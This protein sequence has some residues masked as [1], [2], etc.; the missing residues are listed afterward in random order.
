MPQ[1]GSSCAAISRRSMARC[2]PTAW[3]FR[4]TG[5]PPTAKPRRLDFWLHGRGEKLDELAFIEDRL[6]NKGE[7]TPAG[8]IVL[9]LYGRYCNA[10]KF[11]GE[12][13]PFR[14][15]RR[16]A[17]ALRDRLTAARRARLLDGRREH[18]AVRHASS[19]AC[20]PRRRRARALPRPRSFSKSSAEG[21]DAA[22]LV[23]AGA[24]ALV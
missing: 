10:N 11:A 20:G 24:L 8:A 22:A 13:G 19:P 12:S 5:S 6:K 17:E 18:L 23:G 9:H 4:T 16:R 21:K 1:P 2:S 15:A 7:F 3:S 14:S